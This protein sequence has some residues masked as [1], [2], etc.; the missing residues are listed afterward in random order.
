KSQND[1]A[2][3]GATLSINTLTTQQKAQSDKL[4]GV[5]AKVTPITADSTTLTADSMSN[6][7]S[8]WTIQSAQ[9]D[10]DSALGQRIDVMQASVAN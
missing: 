7:A 6:Q 4:D 1:K 8:S 5:Y 2:V 9:A 10:G 3:A